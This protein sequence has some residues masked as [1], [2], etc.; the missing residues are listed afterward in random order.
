MIPVNISAAD[1]RDR[2]TRATEY[3][4][5][6]P[7]SVT[8]SLRLPDAGDLAVEHDQRVVAESDRFEAL[9]PTREG[10]DHVALP[11]MSATGTPPPRRGRP[12]PGRRRGRGGPR[13]PGRGAMLRGR[14]H[15]PRARSRLPAPRA[16][17][18]PLTGRVHRDL[19]APP[20]PRRVLAGAPPADRAPRARSP[21]SPVSRGCPAPGAPAAPRLDGQAER[22]SG[23]AAARP[24]PLAVSAGLSVCH[25]LVPP[26]ES[27]R[28]QRAAGAPPRAPPAR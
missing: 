8:T 5:F 25:V 3:D 11:P 22:G 7:L 28:S 13:A 2:P 14:L 20:P 6:W 16:T 17:Q 21:L 9:P 12:S 4:K 1:A 15:P 10:A 26:P 23:G 18:A 24:R 27:R 19:W